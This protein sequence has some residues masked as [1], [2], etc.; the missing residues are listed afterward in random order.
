[1][2]LVGLTRSQIAT[3]SHLA[4][5]PRPAPMARRHA[6]LLAAAAQRM[7]AM[8]RNEAPLLVPFVQTLM[9]GDTVPDL[10]AYAVEVA[11]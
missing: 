6:V 10:T 9:V 8:E 7:A 3:A 2:S 1:M 11:S 4:H 5:R